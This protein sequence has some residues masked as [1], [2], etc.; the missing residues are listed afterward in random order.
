MVETLQNRV[1][2]C[3]KIGVDALLGRIGS[4][5]DHFEFN[6]EHY[7]KYSVGQRPDHAIAVVRMEHM[8][9][10]IIQLD[11]LF[12]GTG[13][14]GTYQEVKIT[15]RSEKNAVF[16]S[17]DIS[18]T[19]TIFLCC[20]IAREIEIYQQLILKAWNLDAIQK[21]K[22]ILELPFSWKGFQLGATCRKSLGWFVPPHAALATFGIEDSKLPL[23]YNMS[24]TKLSV[25][26]SRGYN[27]SVITGVN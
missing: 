17:T 6:Y 26:M 15:H 4:C 22:Y 10:D 8:W 21:R 19:N 9:D 14:F 2:E 5:G 13:N 25:F 1:V 7:W 16:L 23:V 24:A 3:S 27:N 20:L 18:D 11:Q 12:G